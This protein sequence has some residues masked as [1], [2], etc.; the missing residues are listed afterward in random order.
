MLPDTGCE[1][2][3]QDWLKAVSMPL[4][5]PK[6]VAEFS[7]LKIGTLQNYMYR[8]GPGAIL[9]PAEPSKGQGK[10]RLW[11]AQEM[12]AAALIA[13][14]VSLG[15]QP[16]MVYQL[17][18]GVAGQLLTSLYCEGVRGLPSSTR[19]M[20]LPRIGTHHDYM[21]YTKFMDDSEPLTTVRESVNSPY[22][23]RIDLYELEAILLK[24]LSRVFRQALKNADEALYNTLSDVLDEPSPMEGT[25]A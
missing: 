8:T 25:V 15:F 9:A 7:H 4:F 23:L 10:A 5:P 18:K 3:K 11:S 22:S 12:L 17:A 24:N 20:H 2:R 13:D 16:S 19:V 14:L 21:A 1:S 6:A